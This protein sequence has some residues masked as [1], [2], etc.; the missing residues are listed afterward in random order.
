MECKFS[1]ENCALK[2]LVLAQFCKLV[3]N[4][5]DLLPEYK[6]VCLLLFHYQRCWFEPRVTPEF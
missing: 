6:F 1:P 5:H 4:K 3:L 2:T